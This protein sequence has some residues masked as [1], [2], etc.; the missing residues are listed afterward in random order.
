MLLIDYE[1]GWECE[2][3]IGLRDGV[4]EEQ[5]SRSFT[6]AQRVKRGV[7]R[8]GRSERNRAIFY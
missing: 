6:K 8:R 7:G 5:D 2:R 1:G 3:G 4:S